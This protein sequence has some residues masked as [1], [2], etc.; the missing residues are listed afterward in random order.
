MK[1]L[2]ALLAICIA[3]VWC[4]QANQPANRF[5]DV[6]I[7]GGQL[8]PDTYP[9]SH[10]FAAVWS[11]N[12]SGQKELCTGISIQ[13]QIILTAAHC[14]F[15]DPTST[16][17]VFS[18]DGN[19]VDPGKTRYV[20]AAK[21]PTHF[22]HAI[23]LEEPGFFYDIALLKLDR[24]APEGTLQMQLPADSV[25]VSTITKVNIAGYGTSSFDG[26][27]GAA[28]GLDEQLRWGIEPTQKAIRKDVIEVDQ[29][30]GTGVCTGDSGGPA[31]A[32][33]GRG[34]VVL[35]TLIDLDI[36][37]GEACR[38]IANY[39]NITHWID[40]IQSNSFSLMQNIN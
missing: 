9:L 37:S 38:S 29:S 14:V 19:D 39:T 2:T 40:W 26:H 34:Y 24:P 33:S 18:S 30:S 6:A 1:R 15:H 32:P 11:T 28:K 3:I 5:P 31:F 17:V 13:P 36:S 7:F 22:D 4:H 16:R 10:Y 21:L 20:T 25:D 12:E 8:L 27:T 23:A 35:G